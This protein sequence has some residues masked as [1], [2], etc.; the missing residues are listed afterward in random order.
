MVIEAIWLK[1][2][3]NSDYDEMDMMKATITKLKLKQDNF[4]VMYNAPWGRRLW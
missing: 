2:R 4:E 1:Q 3:D